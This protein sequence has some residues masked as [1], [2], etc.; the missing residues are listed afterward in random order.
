MY[1]K[2]IRNEISCFPNP[3]RRVP[4]KLPLVTDGNLMEASLIT[5]RNQYVLV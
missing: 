1:I 3:W 4:R 2:F 5:I